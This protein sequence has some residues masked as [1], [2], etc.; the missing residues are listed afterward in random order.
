MHELVYLLDIQRM[1][2]ANGNVDHQVFNRPG[3]GWSGCEELLFIIV[4]YTTSETFIFYRIQL[5]S[6][7]DIK[8]ELY[9]GSI[10]YKKCYN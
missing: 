9:G 3:Y 4:D 7:K 10:L 8:S 2:K 1:I 5:E 6:A